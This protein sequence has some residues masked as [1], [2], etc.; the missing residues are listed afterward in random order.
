MPIGCLVGFARRRY[1]SISEHITHIFEGGELTEGSSCSFFRT[2][3]PDGKIIRRSP[4]QPGHGA[5]ARVQGP[6]LRRRTDRRPSPTPAI[7]GSAAAALRGW[8]P[9][10]TPL[11][12]LSCRLYDGD[13][14]TSIF[15][16]A[17]PPL[18]SAA[19][20][21]TG[22]STAREPTT[23]H[24]APL[25]LAR[26]FVRERSRSRNARRAARGGDVPKRRARAGGRSVVTSAA[27][28]FAR[29]RLST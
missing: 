22:V 3:A 19:S 27:S 25:W 18:Y 21:Q 17:A 10:M 15:H 29:A 6:Q 7:D 24:L 23:D 12:R 28:V 2:T 8:C 16:C 5:D 4:L 11:S 26:S 1:R 9:S 20:G 13:V 14:V